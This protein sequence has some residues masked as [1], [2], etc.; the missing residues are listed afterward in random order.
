MKKFYVYEVNYASGL[1]RHNSRESQHVVSKKKL[2]IGSFIVVEHI[3]CGV[4]IGKV[5]ENVSDGYK[6]EDL[7]Y[8]DV[9][10]F[11]GYTYLQDINLD[12]WISKIE[13]EK[14]KEELEEKMQEKFAEMDK[15][16]KYQYY[17]QFDDEF[18]KL[19]E[20]YKKISGEDK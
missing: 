6:D 7:S 13:K 5:K 1:L 15:I 8:E 11:L 18:N 10:K 16:I 2:K 9:V 20:Q 4:F 14:L 12:A 19:Y 3:D 17:A